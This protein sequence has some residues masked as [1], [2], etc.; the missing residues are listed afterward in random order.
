M[1]RAARSYS[2]RAGCT[3]VAG[4]P[5]P[6]FILDQGYSA[7]GLT[8]TLADMPVQLLVRIAGDRVFHDGRPEP[9]APS[10]EPRKPGPGRN[11]PPRP[12]DL[13]RGPHRNPLGPR[14]PPTGLLAQIR[15]GAHLRAAEVGTRP[16][17]RPT[18]HP[19][20]DPALDL[21]R[22]RRLR[23]TPPRSPPRR[24]PASPLEET[25]PAGPR[26]EPAPGPPRMSASARPVGHPSHLPKTSTPGTW[27]P[28]GRKNTPAQRHPVI[29]KT[30]RTDTGKVEG[31][32]KRG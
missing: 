19:R 14:R 7:S 24:R 25:A 26:P 28:P 10:P 9:R 15:H 3:Q 4:L 6:L 29:A 21:D 8:R 30:V 13:A 22:S 32:K 2:A 27:R 23:P 16:D 31:R 18:A 12:V 17:R 11:P 20:T 1:H 5:A